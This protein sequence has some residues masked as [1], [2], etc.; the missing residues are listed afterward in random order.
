MVSIMMNSPARS[1]GGGTH[2]ANVKYQTKNGA[3]IGW[4]LH[5]KI[6]TSAESVG[7]RVLF[8]EINPKSGELMF[9]IAPDRNPN[10]ASKSS[11]T[12][13]RTYKTAD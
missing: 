6:G 8:S 9:E 3:V 5:V 13:Y 11:F 2:C 7:T 1:T 10:N 12:S 4:G